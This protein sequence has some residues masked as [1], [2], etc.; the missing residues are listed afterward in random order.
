MS[1]DYRYLFI[2]WLNHLSAFSCNDIAFTGVPPIF[3]TGKNPAVFARNG[4]WHKKETDDE[5]AV[6]SISFPR[7]KPNK[8][9]KSNYVL[10]ANALP[11]WYWHSR[12]LSIFTSGRFMT[13]NHN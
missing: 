2:A 10:V 1:L 7:T 13:M 9:S 4:T 12:G 11:P 5:C 6:E 3:A 8:K